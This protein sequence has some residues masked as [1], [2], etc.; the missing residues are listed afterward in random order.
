M[1]TCPPGQHVEEICVAD[2][3]AAWRDLGA[4]PA[5]ARSLAVLDG[6]PYAG[7]ADSHLWEYR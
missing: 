1:L 5:I 6:V 3:L 2:P 7:T 4:V